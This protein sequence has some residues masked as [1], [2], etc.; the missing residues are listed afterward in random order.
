MGSP[1]VGA[2]GGTAARPSRTRR[3]RRGSARGSGSPSPTPPLR[4]EIGLGAATGIRSLEVYWPT[5]DTRQAFRDVAV[6]QA[7]EIREGAESY[8]RT[9]LR[10]FTFAR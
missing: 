4:Q 5:S 10:R 7:I 9:A 3:A 6:D 8:D 2:A 1:A